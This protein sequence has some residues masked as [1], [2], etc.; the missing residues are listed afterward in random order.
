MFAASMLAAEAGESSLKVL[1]A[2]DELLW[3]SIAF[4]LVV[5]ALLK[6][7]FPRM[8]AALQERTRRI[9]GQIEDAE[10]TKREAD[11]VLA[12]YRAK[13]NEARAEVQRIIDEGKKTAESLRA[14]IVAKAET[15]A[16]EIV[17]RA[18]ADVAGE[19]D[20]AIQSLRE[21]LGDLSVQLAARV[22]EKELRSTDEHRALVDRAIAELATS[23]NGRN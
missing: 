22:I 19:R 7:A 18:Q 16:R 13:L 14:D 15:E 23:G 12:E 3:G 21:T 10:R 9:Q 17:A 8:N 2:P 4:L 20:R 1:P 11:Q 5:L 6:F